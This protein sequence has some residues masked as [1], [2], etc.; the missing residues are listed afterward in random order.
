VIVLLARVVKAAAIVEASAVETVVASAAATI[1]VATAEVTNLPL[2]KDP[3]GN[4]GL[5][6]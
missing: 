3:S 2:P 1:A 5:L 4:S 6:L